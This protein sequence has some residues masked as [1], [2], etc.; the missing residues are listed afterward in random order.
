MTD[1]RDLDDLIRQLPRSI[2]PP[3]DLWPDIAARIDTRARAR[4][5]AT[6]AGVLAA[7]AAVALFWGLRQ[8]DDPVRAIEGEWTTAMA[9]PGISPSTPNEHPAG[10]TVL[11]PGEDELQRAATE[12][13]GAFDRRRPLLDRDLLAVY[14]ENLDIVDDAIDRSR[15]ALVSRPEDPHLQRVLDRAY[16]HKLA[17]LRRASSEEASP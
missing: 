8:P 6:I 1:P 17:L 2:D 7:A 15:A 3:A 4:R 10:A 5:R 13:A 12:L 11:I 9:Q 14:E 16:R